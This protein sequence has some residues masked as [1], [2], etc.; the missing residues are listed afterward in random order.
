MFKFYLLADGQA[1]II[2]DPDE[3][4]GVVAY[5]RSE[6]EALELAAAYD[7]GRIDVDNMAWRGRTVACLQA[8]QLTG[9]GAQYCL[10]CGAEGAVK[11][12]PHRHVWLCPS[13][14][15]ADMAPLSLGEYIEAY[16]LSP[17]TEPGEGLGAGFFDMASLLVREVEGVAVFE[18]PTTGARC[19][20][21]HTPT[22][23][24]LMKWES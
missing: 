12:Q 21:E 6:R 19:A 13:C 1:Q 17:E 2:N 16:N 5:A 3:I 22:H 24:R 15:E 18:S 4:S 8:S 14:W 23:S 7:G 9:A 20:I 11:Y 10:D